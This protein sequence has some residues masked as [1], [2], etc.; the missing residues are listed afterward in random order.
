MKIL[1]FKAQKNNN[2]FKK[3]QKV[4][5]TMNGANNAHIRF[6]FRGTGRYVNGVINKWDDS[7]KPIKWNTVIGEGGFKEIEVEEEFANRILA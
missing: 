7:L 2:R 6:K 3:N 4:W 5:V 1:F